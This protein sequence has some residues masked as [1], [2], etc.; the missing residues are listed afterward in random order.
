[1]HH[2]QR[3]PLRLLIAAVLATLSTAPVDAGDKPLTFA[4]L[5]RFKTLHHPSISRD[6]GWIAYDLVPDRG[7]GEA[8]ARS[9]VDLLEHRVERG[10][11]PR[12]SGD[13]LWVAATVEPTLEE[14][15]K[16][17]AVDAQHHAGSGGA[18]GHAA[19]AALEETHLAEEVAALE[20]R[21][22]AGALARVAVQ[23]HGAREHHEERVGGIAGREDRLAVVQAHLG[24]AGRQAFDLA[25][26]EA[27]EERALPQAFGNRRAA[28]QL[29][30]GRHR[31]S[32]SGTPSADDRPD[33]EIVHH[34]VSPGDTLEGWGAPPQWV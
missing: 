26:A 16:V 32:F 23:R 5:M 15:E 10:A 34:G 6:G 21:Q 28:G 1:M 11:D 7:D 29:G 12:I 24:E 22:G 33:Q 18:G 2:V 9:T 25:G 8:V 20:P 27:A 3:S 14:G 19:P 4:D 30:Q 31:C 17:V 13:G